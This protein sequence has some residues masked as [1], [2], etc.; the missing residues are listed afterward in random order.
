MQ[1]PFYTFASGPPGFGLLL[2]RLIAGVTLVAYC[3]RPHDGASLPVIAL[4]LIAAAGGLLLVGLWTPVVGTAVAVIELWG[5]FSQGQ[6]PWV[7]VMLVGLGAA[8]A[9]L[10][11]G[12][13]SVDARL[14]GWKRIEI[15]PPDQRAD[16]F[17]QRPAASSVESSD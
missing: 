15:R 13:W 17:G 8:L 6:D 7:S 1:R 10:G 12:V 5:V 9:L 4:L 14:Y 16:R 3:A 2:L 11:P